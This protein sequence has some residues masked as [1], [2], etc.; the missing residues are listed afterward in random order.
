MASSGL[1]NASPKVPGMTETIMPC[2]DR[3]PEE[4][5][6][7]GRLLAGYGEL[8][9][10]LC[11][12][13][14]VINGDL[15]AA[16]RAILRERGEQKRIGKADSLAKLAY[17]DAGLGSYYCAAISDMHWCRLI[18]NQ[19]AHC[20]WYDTPAEGVCFFDF[21]SSGHS[22]WSDRIRDDEQAPHRH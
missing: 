5:N 12:C 4:G 1:R 20:N 15:D 6:M 21:R 18:R 3:F 17:V 10:E 16:I 2:F 8:E 11:R 7:I 19:Y 13:V 9:L 22:E 14:A